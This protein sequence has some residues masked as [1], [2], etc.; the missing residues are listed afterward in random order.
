MAPSFTVS[1]ANTSNNTKTMKSSIKS[2]VERALP[3]GQYITFKF[4]LAGADFTKAHTKAGSH[5]VRYMTNG[6]IMNSKNGAFAEFRLA[7]ADCTKLVTVVAHQGEAITATSGMPI[8]VL[9]L[10]EDQFAGQD[11]K[12]KF[13]LTEDQVEDI[14]DIEKGS[15]LVTVELKDGGDW[16]SL[17]PSVKSYNGASWNVAK[18]NVVDI[19]AGASLPFGIG[20]SA[21]DLF[22]AIAEGRY[23][24]NVESHRDI[25]ADR[26]VTKIANPRRA[27]KA[28]EAKANH[29]AAKTTP[30]TTQATVAAAPTPAADMQAIIAAAVKQAVEDATAP[31]LS[32]IAELENAEA[33]INTQ[34]VVEAAPTPAEAPAEEDGFVSFDDEDDLDVITASEAKVESTPVS[35]FCTDEDELGEDF[36]FNALEAA[37]ASKNTISQM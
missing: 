36:D 1:S 28:A 34:A 17:N 37:L 30:V 12:F 10:L 31:L 11:T 33:P 29:A 15:L 27:R 4:N 25:L 6:V 22:G 18:L 14:R 23:T 9:E 20:L 16:A 5:V 3:A 19:R 7:N 26:N 13:D 21:N 8:D 32:K 24:A 35:D 2:S